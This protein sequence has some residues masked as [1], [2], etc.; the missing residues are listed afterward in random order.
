[1]V[2]NKAKKGEFLLKKGPPY[3]KSTRHGTLPFSEINPL[4]NKSGFWGTK[5]R[6]FFQIKNP[7]N[8]PL[9]L[10]KIH[11]TKRSEL[12]AK[13]FDIRG[14]FSIQRLRCGVFFTPAPISS[15][16]RCPKETTIRT[17]S[18]SWALRLFL[19]FF[20]HSSTHTVKLQRSKL[21][22]VWV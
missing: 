16:R 22:A 13:S 9:P 5:P 6:D 18:L 12:I 20:L 17:S 15:L 2:P 14:V 21:P 10:R 19:H 3:T 7:Q 8:L 4:T 1:M 11:C